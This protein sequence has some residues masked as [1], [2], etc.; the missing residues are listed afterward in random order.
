MG[1]CSQ[2]TPVVYCKNYDYCTSRYEFHEDLDKSVFTDR[3]QIL[4]NVLVDEM[5]MKSNLLV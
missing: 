1:D 2:Y 3:T 5:G 4:N